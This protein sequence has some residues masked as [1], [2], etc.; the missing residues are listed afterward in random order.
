MPSERVPS[1]VPGVGGKR[2]RPALNYR[3]EHL[4]VTTLDFGSMVAKPELC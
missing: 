4:V 1:S 3:K 2:N